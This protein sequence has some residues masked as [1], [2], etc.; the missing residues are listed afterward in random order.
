MNNITKSGII[1]SNEFD[2]SDV[3]DLI[4]SR[5]ATQSY[6]PAKDTSN[7]C[8]SGAA[9]ILYDYSSGITSATVLRITATISWS[10]F[11]SSSTA[12][13]FKTRWQG[14]NHNVSESA[15][16][17]AGNNYACTALNNAVDLTALVLS[18][19]SGTY[20][21]DTT[22]SLADSF[23]STY[24][25]SQIGIRTDY[26]NGV[27]RLTI[28]DIKIINDKYSSTSATKAHIGDDFVAGREL[29]EI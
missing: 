15:W 21:Y 7:S 9:T 12:G 23:I 19:T 3:M 14:S 16:Q 1:L 8:M 28:H 18:A 6:V 5:S 4:T 20:V 11:D 17:W 10:D 2:E 27:G 26:S 22:F 25:G 13:T 29:I 24:D